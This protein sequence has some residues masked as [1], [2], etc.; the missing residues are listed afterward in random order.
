MNILFLIGVVWY[1]FSI[2]IFGILGIMMSIYDLREIKKKE[3]TIVSSY[4]PLV[5]VLIPAYNENKDIERCIRSVYDTSYSNK[6]IIVIDDGSTDGTSD[7]VTELISNIG[8]ETEVKLIRQRNSGK[9]SALNNGIKYTKGEL[10]MVLDADSTVSTSSMSKMVAH[11][12]DEDVIALAARTH[13]D[14]YK[15]FVGLLQRLE[16]I[17]AFELKKS[18]PMLNINIIVG[19]VGSTFRKSALL[20]VNGYDKDTQTEDMDLTMKLIS[21]FGNKK[22]MVGYASD[23]DVYTPPVKNFKQLVNQRFRWRLGF[24]QVLFKHRELIFNRNTKYSKL[25][26]FYMLPMAVLGEILAVI[27]TSLTLYVIFYLLYYFS[28]NSWL[29][30]M[31]LLLPLFVFITILLTIESDRIIDRGF[32]S[33]LSL[34][35]VIPWFIYAQFLDLCTSVRILFNIKKIFNKGNRDNEGAWNHVDR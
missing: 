35:L 18:L 29:S 22:R 4:S 1:G 24:E 32:I 26:T 14:R 27:N 11:F 19:G 17:Y 2:A 8:T 6:E 13:I 7:I 28:I 23:V 31:Q 33:F 9:G 5:S 25:L 15:N 21:Y 20:A 3:R 12:E 34:F 10:V 16:F 30:N